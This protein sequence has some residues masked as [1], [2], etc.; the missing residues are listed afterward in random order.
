MKEIE[1][2][3]KKYEDIVRQRNEKK[4]EELMQRIKE[5]AE[6][7]DYT[8]YHGK[9]MERVIENDL[10]SRENKQ[11]EEERIKE[12]QNKM[13]E[14]DNTIK[15]THKPLISQRKIEELK[16]IKSELLMNPREKVRKASPIVQSDREELREL[17]LKRKK[18][19]E[20]KNPLKPP[21]PAPRKEFEQKNFLK[22]F[23]DEL[24]EEF[25]RTGKRPIPSYR[26]WEQDLMTDK[27]SNREKYNLVKEK[28]TILEKT[29]KDKQ[30]LLALNG[31]GTVKDAEQVNDL[32]FDSLN[33]KLSLLQT[34]V[35][36]DD[37][38]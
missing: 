5:N 1:E 31:G 25:E 35:L 28:A 38:Q 37:E 24:Q 11:D 6:N 34:A 17:A 10:L 23:Q 9:Y 20:W 32:L 15:Q 18:I 21:T 22:E 26:N 4:K 2:D 12:Y 19:F 3:Q 30:R 29:A 8:K 7:Y 13:R 14:Y 27:Y 33:A 36:K 16:K